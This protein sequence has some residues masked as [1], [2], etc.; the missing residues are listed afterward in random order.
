MTENQFDSD[1]PWKDILE[2]YFPQFV[3]FF[4][5][6]AYREIDWKKGYEFLDK[7][8][9]QIFPESTTGR[10]YVDKLVKVY[11]LDGTEAFVIIH[12]EVQGDKV[13][14]FAERMYIYNYR[15]YDY[16]K[17]R[18]MSLAVLTDGNPNWRPNKF[19]QE[20]WGCRVSLE[21]PVI[22]LSD[23]AEDWEELERSNNPFALV[24]MAHLKTLQTAKDH[25]SRLQ[26]KLNLV[27]MLYHKGYS[28]Q[29]VYELFR[30]IDWLLMLPKAL[31]RDFKDKL[32]EIEEEYKMT[33]V[34]SI[35]R[36]GKEEGIQ[37][38]IEQGEILEK[39]KV[40][41]KQLNKK[42]GLNVQEEELISKQFDPE[43]LDKA[44]D[45]ILFAN[46]K[47]EVLKYFPTYNH[48]S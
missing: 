2:G 21:F 45:E 33:Y 6:V 4:A 44:L 19:E 32:A 1:S 29:D 7:E 34:T 40:L 36:L 18:I 8:F 35:E 10:K 42:F 31:E 17:T 37:E 48:S 20:L 46:S 16:Y 12:I 41:R 9:Q 25:Q 26:W 39:Q 3:S 15:L 13:D 38:G 43:I 30:F 27:K 24:V 14:N 22:K 23:Y 47:E 11:R 28:K 5:P